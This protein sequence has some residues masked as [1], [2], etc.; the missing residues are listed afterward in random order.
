MTKKKKKD[1]S[2]SLSQPLPLSTAEPPISSAPSSSSLSVLNISQRYPRRNARKRDFY[3]VEEENE[4][5]QVIKESVKMQFS[6]LISPTPDCIHPTSLNGSLPST[7]LPLSATTLSSSNV[8]ASLPAIAANAIPTLSSS[9]SLTASLPITHETT[10]D[11]LMRCAFNASLDCHA[12]DQATDDWYRRWRRVVKLSRKQYE[13]P[14]GAV[15]REFVDSLTD[16]VNK[17]ASGTHKSERVIVFC[18]VILQRDL[19]IK[20]AAD[21]RRLLRRRL[22]M[23]HEAAFDALVQDAER[24]D[25]NFKRQHGRRKLV[26]DD[27][28]L[29]KTFTRLMLLGK[30]RD[31]VRWLSAGDT[32]GILN[33][34]T[35]IQVGQQEKN[36]FE[37]LQEKHPNSSEIDISSL[38]TPPP[39]GLPLM[40]EIDI[41]SSHVEL[42]ARRLQGGA[43]PGGTDSMQWKDFL[44]RHGAHSDKLRDAIASLARRLSN[45]IVD[46]KDIQ[47]LLSNRLIALDKCPGV[48]PI[49]IGET[50][51]RLLGKCLALATRS[52]VESECGTKQLCSGMKSGIEG[53]IHTVTDLFNEKADDGWGLLLVDAANA[54]NSL[55]RVMALWHARLHWPRCAKFLFNTYRGYS[56]LVVQGTDQLIYSREGVTQGDPL[57]MMFYGVSLLPLIN[58]LPRDAETTPTWYADDASVIG[59]LIS[60]K[61]WLTD[62]IN[63]GPSYGYYPEPKKSYLVVKE[64]FKDVAEEIFGDLGVKIVTGQRFLGGY[65]GDIEAKQIHVQEK[66][67]NW[68]E[69]LSTLATIAANQPQVAYS[70]FV[71]SIQHEWQFFHRVVP[72]IESAF[73]PLEVLIKTKLLP[74]IFGS[75][76]S[77]SERQLFSLPVRL[78]GLDV[79]DPTSTASTTYR[80]ARNSTKVICNSLRKAE[81]FT[82]ANHEA[83]LRSSRAEK[84]IQDKQR[85]TATFNDVIGDFGPLQQRAVCEIPQE[86]MSAWLTV[87][88]IAKQH[89]DLSPN[90]FRDALSLRYRRSLM[91]APTHCD[92]CGEPFTMTHSLDCKKGGLV[93]QRHNEIRDALGDLANLAWGNCM[94]EPVVR[95]AHAPTNKTSLIADLGVRGVYQQQTVAL[96]DIRVVDTDAQSYCT[97]SIKSVLHS[98]EVT[99]RT[100]YGQACD[101]KRATFTPIVVSADGI[102]AHEA[103]VFISRIADQLS[104][105]WDKPYSHV[106]SWI[107]ARLSLAVIRASD[108]CIRGSRTRWRCLGVHD[109]PSLSLSLA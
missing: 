1:I 96:F 109:G 72:D 82:Q 74:A 68:C 90:E 7:V 63:R 58:S 40:V 14:G 56:P 83:Q 50:L 102:F 16:E 55:N 77:H 19:L 36:V 84:K 28:H 29:L 45:T 2:L 97:R 108:L 106:I 101:E 46:W 91:N 15:G 35:L 41:S 25:S 52:D 95:E 105:K 51:R 81:T 34:Q 38:E 4:L 11:Q 78:G 60:I 93:T 49:G 12:V 59:P 62:L 33:P 88:P 86:K 48:R 24:C 107:R 5:Q 23:W 100:K 64:K 18:S 20:K 71:K 3:S 9:P 92:G 69:Q 61:V 103:K 32:G 89:F 65:I 27:G 6:R 43:G 17:L 8:S 76:I 54:F 42:A 75:H 13:L 98:A 22:V 104:Y 80:M 85:N 53:A 39:G 94:R 57:S 87:L 26:S 44:L 10:S 79:Q 67:A 37:I 31:A 99:K 21:I 70:A 30:V 47:S 73:E 66:I